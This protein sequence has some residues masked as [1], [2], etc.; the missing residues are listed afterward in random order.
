[1]FACLAPD[2]LPEQVLAPLAEDSTDVGDALTLLTSYRMITRTADV[3][4]VHRL[5]QAVTRSWPT[6]QHETPTAVAVVPELTAG[7][8]A[9]VHVRLGRL[10]QAK[11][12]QGV[13][14]V[15]LCAVGTGCTGDRGWRGGDAGHGGATAVAP[16]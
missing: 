10:E 3:V 12:L 4:S 14:G 2:A 9:D 15:R 11:L 13:P 8:E 5:V 16:R 7:V 6:T 1:L